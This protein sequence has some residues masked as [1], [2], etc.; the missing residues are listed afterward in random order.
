MSS[1]VADVTGAF[2]R[3]GKSCKAENRQRERGREIQNRKRG[4][5]S[6]KRNHKKKQL[7]KGESMNVKEGENDE[8]RRKEKGEGMGDRQ[9]ERMGTF[10]L[11][12]LT[13]F[14]K[15]EQTCKDSGT[16]LTLINFPCSSK[17]HNLPVQWAMMQSAPQKAYSNSPLK[18]AQSLSFIKQ[19]KCSMII[20]SMR[21]LECRML[22]CKLVDGGCNLV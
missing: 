6:I 22:I 2:M 11:Q 17:G 20:R 10:F 3:Y 12:H 5:D 1:V 13:V 21:P 18:C 19:I 9:R 16:F 8:K 4:R 14:L 7:K 15:I